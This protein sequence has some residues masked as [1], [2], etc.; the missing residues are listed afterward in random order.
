MARST[1]CITSSSLLPTALESFPA[2]Q[3]EEY[4]KLLQG[5]HNFSPISSMLM[6]GPA[7]KFKRTKGNLKELLQHHRYVL[8]TRQIVNYH[9]HIAEMPKCRVSRHIYGMEIS[10]IRFFLQLAAAQSIHAFKSMHPCCSQIH[11]STVH[12]MGSSLVH[13]MGP[14]LFL[15]T[16]SFCAPFPK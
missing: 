10:A 5:P 12:K 6:H 1:T 14:S 8:R 13:K 15:Y 4:E 16:T 11:T 9:V 7:T 2:Q 3:Q